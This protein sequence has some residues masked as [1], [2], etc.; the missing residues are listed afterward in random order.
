MLGAGLLGAELQ[1]G[2]GTQHLGGSAGILFARK[3]QHQLVIA[4]G[5]EGGFRHTQAVD[6]AV[7]HLLHRL[8]LLLLHALDRAV[9]Q[10]LQRQLTAALQVEPQ[11]GR[12]IQNKSPGG[13]RQGQDQGE[14]P[15]LTCH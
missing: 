15:L 8:Q 5:L 1:Q 13:N 6:P 2:R 11:R 14:P 12:I 7:E 9:R 10:H 3:L 4:H